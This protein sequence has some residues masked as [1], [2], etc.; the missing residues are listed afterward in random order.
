LPLKDGRIQFT[1]I[2]WQEIICTSPSVFHEP[3]SKLS[4][5]FPYHFW[6]CVKNHPFIMI[7]ADGMDFK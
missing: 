1:H 7:R 6:G 2:H 5:C 4:R 3:D